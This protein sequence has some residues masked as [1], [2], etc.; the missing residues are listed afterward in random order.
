VSRKALAAGK[1]TSKISGYRLA[2]H[3]KTEIP[4]SLPGERTLNQRPDAASMADLV[5]KSRK[6]SL[7]VFTITLPARQT[8]D[9]I[10]GT[11]S[12][13]VGRTS[14]GPQRH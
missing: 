1:N 6:T 2:A 9:L 13:E 12:I 7:R 4:D 8:A 11:L 5:M 3:Y 14:T 10:P